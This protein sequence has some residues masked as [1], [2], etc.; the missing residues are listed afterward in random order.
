M[1]DEQKTKQE[2]IQELDLLRQRV[3]DLEQSESANKRAE[4]ALRENE[5]QYRSLFETSTNAILIRNREG[6]MTMANE[7][8]ISLLGATKADDLIGKAYLD[9]VHP[10]DRALSAERVEK[11]FQLALEKTKPYQDAT[12]A[13]LPREHRMV[14]MNGDVIYV[15]STAV[16]FHHKRELFIQGIFRNITER[17]RAE[18]ALMQVE[19][20]YRS[21]FDE[22]PVGY[23]EVDME[24]YVKKVNQTESK[25]LGYSTEEMLGQP[26]W[27][28]TADP[29]KVKQVFKAKVTGDLSPGQAFERF[30]RR[31]D[32]TT[33][34]VIAEDGLLKNSIGRIIG[35]RTTIQDIT[36]HK[37]AEEALRESE[38]KYSAVVQQAKDGVLIIQDHLLRFV[39][40]SMTDILGYG[41]DEVENTSFID[42]VAPE[43]RAMVAGRVKA[44]LAG[45][46]VPSTYEAKLVHKDGT[47]VDAELSA[48]IIQYRGRPADVGIIRDITRR[49]RAEEALKKSEEQ[50]K[51]L[52]QEN[53]IMAAIGRTIGSTLNIDEVYERFA[54]EARKL[55]PFDRISINIFDHEEKTARTAY[56]AGV[57]VCERQVGAVYPLAGSAGE[58]VMR[59]RS[60]L[61]LHPLD[62][63]ELKERFPRLLPAFE[64]GH[65]S[66]MIV[67]LISKNKVIGNLYFG[68][69]QPKS[70]TERDLKLAE[71]IGNQ[72][73]GTIASAQLFIERK[74]MEETLRESEERFRELYDHAPVSYHEYD[75]EGRITRVN[76]T[77]LEMLGYT[78]E[79]MIGQPIWKFN[80]EEEA[81][82]KRVLAKLAGD[83]VP[84][85]GYELAYRRKDGT[86]IWL[87]AE[88]RLILDPEGR[89]TGMRGIIQDITERKRVEEALR[90][91][92]NFLRQVL[93]TIP[94]PIAYKNR[95]RIYLGCNTAFLKF[96]GL[97]EE[98]I[99]GKTVHE[100]FPRDLADRYYQ[101]DSELFREPGE[102][103]YESEAQH[104]DG[105][106]HDIIQYKAT[107]QDTDGHTAGLISAFL[108][109]TE[110]K[111][112]EEELKQTNERLEQATSRANEMAFQAE[113]ANMAK[114][115]FLANMSHEIRTPMNGV[116][117]M[118]GLLLDTHLSP[119]QRQ[120]AEIVRSSG[121]SLLL[122]INDILDFSKIEA[123]KLDMETLDFDLYTT[124]EDFGE[125]LAVR[126]N[127]KGIE[128]NCMVDP[129][130][131]AL[132]RGDPGR[133]RQ[134]LTN[135]TGNA[136]KFTHQGTIVVRAA[137]TWKKDASVMVRFTVSDTGIGISKDRI[138][139]LFS[140]FVQADGS[141]TR[142]YGGTGLG[143]AIS[144]QLVGLMGG[145]IGVDSEEGTGSTFWFTAVFEKQPEGTQKKDLTGR[146][147]LGALA[148][149]RILVVD[150][151]EVNRQIMTN[152][153]GRWSFRHDEAAD[154]RTALSMLSMAAKAGDPYR[155][156]FLDMIMP[157][158]DGEELGRRIK[159]EPALAD[160]HLILMTSVSQR[161]DAE[162]L[163]TIGFE[164]YLPKPVKRH[165]LLECLRIVLSSPSRIQKEGRPNLVTRYSINEARRARIRILLAEDNITNQQVAMGIL[166]KQ[167]Y[168]VD[169]T[170]NGK[171]AVK[172]LEEISYDLVFMDCQMPEMDGFEAT[173]AIRD[174]QSTVLN[175][176]V[177]IIAMTAHAM[178]GDR[179][180]CMAAGMDDYLA[181]PVMP[182]VLTDM[183]AKWI[184]RSGDGDSSERPFA[185]PEPGDPSN[186]ESLGKTMVET[187]V[188]DRKSL[189][190]RLMNDEALILTI[191]AA[192]LQD[193]PKQ[194]QALR[195]FIQSSDAL[196]T[197]RQAHTI[198]GAAANVGASRLCE[199]A[200][201]MEKA[202]EAGDIQRAS[203][204]LRQLDEAFYYLAQV[205]EHEQQN[206]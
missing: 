195:G 159:A 18:E 34:V 85:K 200:Y 84:S 80:D 126:A 69:S 97:S 36:E 19:E 92:S 179:E 183:L 173:R 199:V 148:G 73:A 202:G 89:I 112:A 164:G 67:P 203:L 117:G 155:A 149:T 101:A 144:K 142:K 189:Q 137:L 82:R 121:E 64:A 63:A 39:N 102:Q 147:S 6:I 177:P 181:K 75:L 12:K 104:T 30:Y 205:L 100:V 172:A 141:T 176:R 103:V 113:I 26:I 93:D 10:E 120:Y 77:E 127:D 59:T 107:F 118:T 60:G 196:Q 35:I 2:L 135:L 146:E 88:D 132:L 81:A 91:Q 186:E 167:G 31:K 180:R 28:F 143:L 174:S 140:P 61:I 44:R 193:I 182:K 194:I 192:F 78:Q 71:S 115:E 163:R 128:F 4:E 122:L 74:Q 125:S 190:E 72:I 160:T 111:K 134:I 17:K 150:D 8:A 184:V 87:L 98:Q 204:L 187:C 136:V 106:R 206:S 96:Y 151:N 201:E 52:A 54:G 171:E 161:G 25:M 66:M 55:I 22:A 14:K 156:A 65:R 153:L 188:F 114:S 50:A 131:P 95:Q 13:I 166:K 41:P 48:C 76:R 46:N 130:V 108:D 21:L 11:I 53:A 145:E 9:F 154:A 47:I 185:E 169:V 157:G 116:I 23:H 129:D 139:A 68:S 83:I 138:S 198:K 24:G 191:I 178:K 3:T 110:R 197:R 1:T 168:R 119:E 20:K 32:G 94:I 90:G 16:A 37:R 109:I 49:K 162:R 165:V 42:Y 105:S 58:E 99:L 158:M 86:T 170:A 123:G 79:E 57:A 40:K 45:E 70:F 56:S 175:R 7:A 15:E 27:K 124:I 38:E 133:L 29:E 5:E 33:F 43:S 62:E 51:Q 152:H